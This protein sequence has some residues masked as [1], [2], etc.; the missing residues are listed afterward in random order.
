MFSV[1]AELSQALQCYECFSKP[2]GNCGEKF[3]PEKADIVECD[4]QATVCVLLYSQ[5]EYEHQGKRKGAL[6]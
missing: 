2:E 6:G 4:E 1:L 3:D 5:K